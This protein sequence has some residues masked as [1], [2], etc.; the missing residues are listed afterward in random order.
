MLTYIT[1]LIDTLLASGV[2][3][4]GHDEQHI[5]IGVRNSATRHFVMIAATELAVQNY[6]TN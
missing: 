4:I 1:A 6:L 5:Y 3:V 2:H